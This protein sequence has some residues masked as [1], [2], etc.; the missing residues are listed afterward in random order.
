MK[1]IGDV[2]PNSEHSDLLKLDKTN[3]QMRRKLEGVFKEKGVI[4]K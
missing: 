3:R 2:V 4:L 1:T